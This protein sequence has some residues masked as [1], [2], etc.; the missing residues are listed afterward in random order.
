MSRVLGAETVA[1]AAPSAGA[2]PRPL[3]GAAR[4]AIRTVRATPTT[5]QETR[6]VLYDGSAYTTCAAKPRR[7]GWDAGRAGCRGVSR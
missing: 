1:F 4:I 3:E 2:H 7:P 6:S 5:L